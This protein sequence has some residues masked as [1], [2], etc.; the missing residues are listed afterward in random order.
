[1]KHVRSWGGEYAGAPIWRESYL[2]EY[3][4]DKFVW[5][6]RSYSNAEVTE[7]GWLRGKGEGGGAPIIR[8]QRMVKRLLDEKYKQTKEEV[9][10]PKVPEIRD[11]SRIILVGI[12]IIGAV[13][14]LSKLCASK[15]RSLY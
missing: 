4:D 1:M 10:P 3:P 8:I 15:R 11:N 14:L 7:P 12:L 5:V 2:E 6:T 13:I 9:E